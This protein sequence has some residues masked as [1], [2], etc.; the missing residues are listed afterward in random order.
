MPVPVRKKGYRMDLVRTRY[1]HWGS[2]TAFNALSPW[3]RKKG[4]RVKDRMVPMD[5]NR[6]PFR[7]FE[8]SFAR[9]SR[10]RGIPEFRM[11]DFG[12]DLRSV[13]AGAAGRLDLIHLLD[14][15]HSLMLLPRWV[16]A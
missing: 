14:G 12:A 11:R 15:E 5:R 2:H 7:I 8:R 13:F 3:L 16:R 1:P 6:F 4:W 9:E 10:S